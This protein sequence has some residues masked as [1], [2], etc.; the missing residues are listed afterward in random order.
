MTYYL[1][2][3]GKLVEHVMLS[4]RVDVFDCSMLTI[5]ADKGRPAK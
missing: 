1:Q 5:P 4:I 3:R 2:G